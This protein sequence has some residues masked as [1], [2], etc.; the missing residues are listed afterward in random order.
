LQYLLLTCG[1]YALF[2]AFAAVDG[3]KLPRRT[4]ISRL[5]LALAAVVIGLAIGAVQY[6]PVR[7]YVR[8]SPR[9]G[10]LPDYRAAT[11]YAWPPEELFNAYLPQFSGMLDNYWGRNIIHLHSDYV[12][13]VVLMLAGAAFL[14]LRADPRRK[15]ILF[16]SGALVISVLWSLGS[17]TP[18]YRIPYAIIPGTKYFRAPATI[19]FVGTLALALLA[20]AGTER[21][22]RLG[23]S[24][25]YVVGWLVA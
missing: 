21:L 16:W 7:E 15:Q 23:V 4:A 22:L 25:K 8:W 2:L 3:V 19:F 11:S 18:F 12:G 20:S 13:V 14:G 24:R 6:L 17:A 9:A 5:G 1:A 10:R